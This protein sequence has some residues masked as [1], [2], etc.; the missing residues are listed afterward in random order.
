MRTCGCYPV[1]VLC[2]QEV[3]SPHLCG[4][5]PC[6]VAAKASAPP[7]AIVGPR[8]V[9]PERRSGGLA[10]SQS[11]DFYALSCDP[12]RKQARNLIKTAQRK[13]QSSSSSFFLTRLPN[14]CRTSSTQHHPDWCYA[15][16]SRSRL[17]LGLMEG[18]T[19]GPGAHLQSVP[20]EAAW[21]PRLSASRRWTARVTA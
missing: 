17:L 9:T 13:S 10:W 8:L 21:A 3:V 14:T 15:A 5:V 1:K 20:L 2:C 19:G 18:V 6:Q 12:F 16:G 4:V 7:G 11:L